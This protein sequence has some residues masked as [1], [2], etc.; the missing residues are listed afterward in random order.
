MPAEKAEEDQKYPYG[1]SRFEYENTALSE[2]SAS[3]LETVLISTK[4]YNL[5]PSHNDK[6]KTLERCKQESQ[7]LI[8]N[9]K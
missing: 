6:E 7:H 8:E 2:Y 3:H 4:A 9:I 1:F 5:K